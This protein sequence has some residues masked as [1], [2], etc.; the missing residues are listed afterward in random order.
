[1]RKLCSE[2]GARSSLKD[3][4]YLCTVLFILR[5]SNSEI[6]SYK[7][8]DR[9]K[10]TRPT[11]LRKLLCEEKTE[12]GQKVAKC[13]VC[14]YLNQKQCNY[15]FTGDP[16]FLNHLLGLEPI[17]NQ[18]VVLSGAEFSQFQKKIHWFKSKTQS[19]RLYRNLQHPAQPSCLRSP[20]MTV[21]ASFQTRNRNK[22][23][24]R[25]P[26]SQHL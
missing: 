20:P 23:F 13:S 17:I 14:F 15:R 7:R 18:F 16:K 5:E 21:L 6:I 4:Y 26:S 25:K 2:A 22:P 9:Q 24:L 1:M 11:I 19:P 10:N 12:S 8:V 3:E